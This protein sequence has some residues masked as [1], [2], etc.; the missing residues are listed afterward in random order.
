[1]QTSFIIVLTNGC[2]DKDQKCD[3][4]KYFR[5]NR[6]TIFFFFHLNV[7]HLIKRSIVSNEINRVPATIL[8]CVA[9][10][11]F[12]F[13]YSA[14]RFTDRLPINLSSFYLCRRI[15]SSTPFL[16]LMSQAAKKPLRRLLTFSFSLPGFRLA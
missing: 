7:D 14:K 8:P 9:F 16:I 10:E 12:P 4:P 11:K 15:E 5:H 13:N 3:Q 1:M 2:V 6:T